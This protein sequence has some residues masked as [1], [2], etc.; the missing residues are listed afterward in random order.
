MIQGVLLPLLLEC[1][2]K[3]P[4]AQRQECACNHEVPTRLAGEHEHLARV[5]LVQFFNVAVFQ[6][7]LWNAET[8]RSSGSITP[9]TCHCSDTLAWSAEEISTR[10]QMAMLFLSL[11]SKP[12]VLCHCTFWSTKRIYKL[13]MS[14]KPLR[15]WYII[16][17]YI[18]IC[19]CIIYIY[20]SISNVCTCM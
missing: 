5:F 3:K 1:A 16:Y 11:A 13:Q 4:V 7:R 14:N 8:K 12:L 9:N 6:E 10:H 17:I 2:A 20:L 19:T 15:K 18:Y